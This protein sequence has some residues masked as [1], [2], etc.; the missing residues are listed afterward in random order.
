MTQEIITYIVIA[1]AVVIVLRKLFA[2]FLKNNNKGAG[3]TP[4]IN[5]RSTT[6]VSDC[7]QCSSDCAFYKNCFQDSKGSIIL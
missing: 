6:G 7:S 3:E 4:K 5:G 2:G 1:L